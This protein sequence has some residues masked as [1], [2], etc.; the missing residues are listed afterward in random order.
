MSVKVNFKKTYYRW[1]FGGMGFHNS[2]VSMTPMISDQF[3][4]ERVLKTYREISPTFSR[5]FAGFGDWTEEAMEHFAEYY[6]KTFAQNDC[7]VYMVPWRIPH[8]IYES[9]EEMAKWADNVAQ[10][11]KCVME[12]KDCKLIRYYCLTNELATDIVWNVYGQD[13]ERFKRHSKFL[14]DAFRKYELD[15]VKLISTDASGLENFY[16]IDWALNNMDE[17]T[18]TYCTHHYGKDDC[19]TDTELYYHFYK[20]MRN[21]VQACKSKQ[22]RYILGEFGIHTTWGQS[23]IMMP[24]VPDGFNKPEKEAETALSTCVKALAAMNAGVYAT[25]YWTMIDYPDPYI[26]DNGHTPEAKARHEVSRFTGWNTS[27][28]YNKNGMV[29]WTNDGDYSANAYMYSMGLMV[30]FFRKHSNVLAFE[31]SD[32]NVVC[33]GTVNLDGSYSYCIMNLSDEAQ[34]IEFTTEYAVNKPF[35]VYTYDSHKVPYND[36]GDLQGY[37]EMEMGENGVLPMTMQ[38]NSMV[39]LTTD[40]ADRTPS[41]ITDIVVENNEISWSASGDAEHCYYRVFEDG[42]QIGS[43]V[44]EYLKRNTKPDAVY[45]V[46]SVDKYG[47]V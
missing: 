42:V 47:N 34:E 9:D 3:M 22:K 16:Q 5:L 32:Q 10:K 21:L 14:F 6:H 36:F 17:L 18:D 12:E 19:K 44:A 15:N 8:H 28:R 43:T 25:A 45:T 2:E 30:R 11:L 35:R 13:L 41:A 38:P 1:L 20:I 24:D 33:G 29:H 37:E 31:T 4:N 23:D 40:Y 7:S 39:I 27:I 26:S 46:K